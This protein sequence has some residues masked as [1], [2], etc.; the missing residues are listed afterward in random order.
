MNGNLFTPRMGVTSTERYKLHISD[1]DH[2]K[3]MRGQNWEAVVTDI[4]TGVQYQA[5]GAECSAGPRCFCDAIAWPVVEPRT[6]IIYSTMVW[7]NVNLDGAQ[8]GEEIAEVVEGAA[9]DFNRA[10]TLLR[11]RDVGLADTLWDKRDGYS[12]LFET[13]DEGVAKEHG[14]DEMLRPD[15]ED[16]EPTP[17]TVGS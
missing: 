16:Y 15:A 10:L 6:E 13:T 5:R 11:T 17:W 2:A 14:F 1:E 4:V 9:A 3:T 7:L 12:L 8:T